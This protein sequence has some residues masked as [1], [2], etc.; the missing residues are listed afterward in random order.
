[1]RFLQLPFS[2]LILA[3]MIT[4][5]A[6]CA[7]MKSLASLPDSHPEALMVGQQGRCR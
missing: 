2:V 1:M 3:G 7:N 4:F 6:A 5:L